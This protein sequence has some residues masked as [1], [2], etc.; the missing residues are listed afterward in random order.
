MWLVVVCGWLQCVAGYGVYPFVV[1]AWLWCVP[2]CGVVLA[3]VCPC[4]PSTGK[5]DTDGS[6][7]LTRLPVF[8]SQWARRA[9]R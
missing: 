9:C 3:V 1:C 5:V 2:G 8:I 6:L 7:E 4:N